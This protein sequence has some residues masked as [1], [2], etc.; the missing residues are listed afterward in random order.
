LHLPGLNV[1]AL[2]GPFL[3]RD[4]ARSG[5]YGRR[6]VHSSETQHLIKRIYTETEKKNEN[7]QAA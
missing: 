1:P 4:R 3:R 6:R 2:L 5:W 7:W